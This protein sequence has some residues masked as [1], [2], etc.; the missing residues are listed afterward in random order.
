MAGREPGPYTYDTYD[1]YLAAEA[2][3]GLSAAQTGTAVADAAAEQQ[4]EREPP[5]EWAQVAGEPSLSADL[6]GDSG[7]WLSAAGGTRAQHPA[8]SSP[9]PS[10]P[11]AEPGV[12]LSAEHAGKRKRAASPA[13]DDAPAYMEEG[14]AAGTEPVAGGEQLGLGGAEEAAG[15]WPSWMSDLGV[16]RPVTL[17]ELPSGFLEEAASRGAFP[18]DQ[19]APPPA[20]LLQPQGQTEADGEGEAGVAG[21]GGQAAWSLTGVLGRLGAAAAN[22][23]EPLSPARPS[24]AALRV[25]GGGGGGLQELSSGSPVAAVRCSGDIFSFGCAVQSCEQTGRNAHAHSRLV[26]I[27]QAPPPPLSSPLC[28][29]PNPSHPSHS[30]PAQHPRGVPHSSHSAGATPRSSLA[31]SLGGHSGPGGAAAGAGSAGGSAPGVRLAALLAGTVTAA[32]FADSPA[33]SV[34]WDDEAAAAPAQ[35]CHPRAAHTR[36]GSLPTQEA[37]LEGD[38]GDGSA[39]GEQRALA[40]VRSPGAL[41]C[42]RGASPTRS[43]SPQRRSP[44]PQPLAPAVSGRGSAS[45]RRGSPSPASSRRSSAGGQAAVGGAGQTAAA[46]PPRSRLSRAEPTQAQPGAAG[47]PVDDEEEEMVYEEDFAEL[48]SESSAAEA[49]AALAAAAS[50]TGLAALAA[51]AAAAA[52]TPRDVPSFTFNA[53]PRAA[54]A[55]VAS[56]ARYA[57]GAASA[58]LSSE[59]P[60]FSMNNGEGRWAA[61]G[62]IESDGGGETG[63]LAA[64]SAAEGS[65]AAGGVGWGGAEAEADEEVVCRELSEAGRGEGATTAAGSGSQPAAYGGA[66]GAVAREEEEEL[67]LRAGLMAAVFGP[68][69]AEA[70]LAA[71]GLSYRPEAAQGGEEGGHGD[72]GEG[73]WDLAEEDAPGEGQLERQHADEGSAGQPGAASSQPGSQEGE[74]EGE[75]AEGVEYEEEDEELEED[76]GAYGGYGGGGYGGFPGFAGGGEGLVLVMNEAGEPMLVLSSSIEELMMSGAAAGGCGSAWDGRRRCQGGARHTSSGAGTQPLGA[77]RAA[78]SLTAAL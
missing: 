28:F 6:P 5:A 38:G 41:V 26:A 76:E 37:R 33:A 44:P 20:A 54:A 10:S 25:L 43:G 73:S 77:S 1:T 72:S 60:G 40:V 61:E 51:A 56:A 62:D 50:G 31:S 34:N 13:D 4:A 8:G 59:L 2:D 17:A 32:L 78:C 39:A 30:T 3:P 21:A 35:S 24:R 46:S 47:P 63:S 49:E 23:G 71:A 75:E 42:S 68:A 11:P 12:A 36:T 52:F 66:G 45:P 70:L 9:P 57:A 48:S 58:E 15:S 22:A 27:E 53:P 65:A 19:R 14:A 74:A 16:P 18:R 55:A 64:G 69:A 67:R 29:L 7:P